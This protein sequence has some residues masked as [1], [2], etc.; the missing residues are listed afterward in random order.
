MSADGTQT[1]REWE[2]SRKRERETDTASP[3]LRA[4]YAG[5]MEESGHKVR[6]KN[7]VDGKRIWRVRGRRVI[8]GSPEEKMS[9]WGPLDAGC[10]FDVALDPGA[11]ELAVLASAALIA[12]GWA[13][14]EILHEEG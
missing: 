14:Y 4:C 7:L 1:L 5:T 13:H 2:A 12:P 8:P 6:A 3:E 10:G 9:E 11:D